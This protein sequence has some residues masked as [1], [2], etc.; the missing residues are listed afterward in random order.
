[1]SKPKE[2]KILGK[3]VTIKW[4][5]GNPTPANPLLKSG[6]IGK[7]SSSGGWCVVDNTLSDDQQKDTLIHEL[8]HLY[9][10]DLNIALVEDQIQ[11][12]AACTYQ[13]MRDNPKFVKWIMK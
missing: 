13:L 4:I 8:F 10:N 7:S 2:L 11:R 3:R 9:N 12:M 6:F 5:D 1:M